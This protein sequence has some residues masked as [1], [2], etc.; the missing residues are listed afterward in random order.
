MMKRAILLSGM[1]FLFSYSVFSQSIINVQVTQEGKTVVITYDLSGKAGEK[2]SITLEV[3]QDG[4][5]TYLLV[6]RSVTGDIGRLISAGS[7]KRIVWDALKD[8]E[9]LVGGNFVF[10][11]KGTGSE[12]GGSFTDSRDGKTYKTVK[13]GNQVWMA[14]NLNYD[15]G[16]GSYC[17]DNSSSNCA[18]YGRLYTWEAAKRAPPPGW[19]LPGKAEFY[20]LLNYLGS[21][22]STAYQK[23]IK[24]GSSRFSV[25]FGG[26]RYSNGNYFNLGS[27]AYFWS[28]TEDDAGLAWNLYVGSNNQKANMND[29]GK[30]RAFSVR[31]VKD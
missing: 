12:S 3:S 30:D 20:Q 19:H 11:I 1:F 29:Y 24:G 23:L 16:D 18:K 31:C 9:K 15:A 4:G 17:Y 25:L 26:W 22:A 14:E 5:Q 7:N 21:D 27:I 10:K 6:P 8:V 28:A 13:I 2:Y